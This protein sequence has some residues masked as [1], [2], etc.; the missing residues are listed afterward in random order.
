MTLS[1]VKGIHPLQ[2]GLIG[3][4]LA[5]WF[6]ATS[7]AISWPARCPSQKALPTGVVLTQRQPDPFSGGAE[8]ETEREGK[9]GGRGRSPR[10][11]W[12]RQ[13]QGR[14]LRPWQS[15]RGAGDFG[16]WSGDWHPRGVPEW[17][18]SPCLPEAGGGS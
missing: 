11:H 17:L 18:S 3:E 13:R 9:V 14:C 10:S 6:K 7:Q 4:E 12:E 15:S 16:W 8:S 5:A 2:P 1:Q